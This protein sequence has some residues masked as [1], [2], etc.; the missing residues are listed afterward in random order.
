MSVLKSYKQS[1]R[2]TA[3]TVGLIAASAFTVGA[4][5]YHNKRI[6]ELERKTKD[7]EGSRDLLLHGGAVTADAVRFLVSKAGYELP[8][9]LSKNFK[10][11]IKS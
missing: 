9:E 3:V 4:I 11:G 6:E 8:T 10:E 7:L 5:V 2:S 1:K